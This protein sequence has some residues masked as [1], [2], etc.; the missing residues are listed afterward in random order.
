[1]IQHCKKKLSF[2]VDVGFPSLISCNDVV[3][4]V[5]T[6]NFEQLAQDKVAGIEF[7][8]DRNSSAIDDQ[9]WQLESKRNEISEALES[10]KKS[11][12]E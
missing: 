7:E 5:A 4:E 9:I 6:L 8:M 1:M 2:L 3:V 12:V 11:K 10:M